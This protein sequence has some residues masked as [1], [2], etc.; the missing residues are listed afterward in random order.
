MNSTGRGQEQVP[1]MVQITYT[2]SRVCD[3]QFKRGTCLALTRLVPNSV[4][5][6]S[7]HGGSTDREYQ[8]GTGY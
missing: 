5:L 8:F 2:E 6:Q 3:R 7:E 1:G 4:I